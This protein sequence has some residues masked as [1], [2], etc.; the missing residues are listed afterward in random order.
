MARLGA[1][2][3]GR[4]YLA[5]SAGG[6]TVAVKVV[7]A[8]LAGDPDFRARFRREV[9]AAQSVDGAYTA[10]VVDADRDSDSP[11][12]ATA[13]VLGPSLTDAVVEYGPLPE[14]TVRALG[15]VL[16]EALGAI[17]GT[18]LIH[19][20]L[21]PSNV[22]LAADG[23]RVI[24]FGIARALDGGNLTSTGVIVGSPG[25]MSPEQAS[26][27]PV[28]P[29]GDVFSLG[30]VLAFAA[31]GYGPFGQ[32][33]AAS[34]L[35]R[36]VHD[37]PELGALP[38]GLREAVGACLAKDPAD[39]PTPAQL[40]AM[41]A[42][43]GTEELLRGG[44]LPTAVASGIA[45]HAA[46]VMELE[47]PA[48]RPTPVDPRTGAAG[49]AA[50]AS[51]AQGAPAGQS[52]P[53]GQGMP[54]EGT[55]TLGQGDAPG[56]PEH[57]TVLLGGGTAATP[58]GPPT[59][60]TAAAGATG[61]ADA[62]SRRR[63]LF[64]ALGALGVAVVGGGTALALSSHS[65]ATTHK[66]AGPTSNG[67]AS[68]S[69]SPSS[70]PTRAAGVPPQPLWTFPGSSL[71]MAP[72]LAGHGKVFVFSDGPTTALDSA[73]GKVAWTG[74]QLNPR[75]PFPAGTLAGGVLVGLTGPN[76]T[77]TGLDPSS[78]GQ[79]WTLQS[80]GGY[81]FGLLLATDDSSA[82]LIGMDLQNTA[83]TYVLAID[84][85]TRALRWAQPRNASAD[86]E[87]AGLVSGGYLV[88][89]NDQ[90]NVVVRST[91]D[92]RQLWSQNFGSKDGTQTQVQPLI[93]GSTLYVDG[94]TLLGFD[95]A[96]GTQ[97]FASKGPKTVPYYY[98]PA[99]GEGGTVY[100]QD[101]GDNGHLIALDGTSGAVRWE[102]ELSLGIVPTPVVTIGATVFVGQGVEPTGLYAVEQSGGH[103]LWNFQD[104]QTDKDW[105][106]STDGTLL[107]AV[108]GEKL[109][110]LPPV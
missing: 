74:P 21:K 34:M 88:Y 101:M 77:L 71:Q 46:R 110:G 22:L 107:F 89:T 108:H 109:Y 45:Q 72:A 50:P 63:L 11:W 69:A 98:L 58:A 41:L 64:G 92:G 29:P 5:R 54:A 100:V 102:T 86:Y 56:G 90:N 67:S 14:A 33:S 13:Y 30:S 40:V 43:D 36:V 19:R 8:E 80:A 91:G 31:T 53:A 35:Y 73:T 6:R 60:V 105:Y 106:L 96:H 59:V 7:R 42:P 39:R 95:L 66:N 16:A 38:E 78:G 23:P 49:A 94:P 97:V 51:G 68:P 17:H 37:A 1:G 83:T 47:T 28:G 15:A 20:D 4:V 9:S 24:D 62:P 76:Q 3:M 57:G 52:T 12:L 85:K 32:D 81:G 44:W 79:L 75:Y 93:M 2:G 48:P 103:Q 25:F 70:F 82:Y 26:G 87:V 18:G 99:A 27:R 61:G 104:G 84:L 65:S 10:P 55:V